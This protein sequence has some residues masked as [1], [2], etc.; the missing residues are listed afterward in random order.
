MSYCTVILCS[1]FSDF[2]LVVILIKMLWLLQS[3]WWLL[4][5]D[6]CAIMCNY[7]MQSLNAN[8]ICSYH[9]QLLYTNI[10]CCDYCSPTGGYLYVTI[11]YN[12]SISLALYALFMFYVATKELLSSYAPVLKFLTVKSIIF[13]TFWQG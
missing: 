5:C 6:L 7:W 2:K 9:I 8:I 3:H 10:K 11:I 12:I 13:L 4:V 1:Y